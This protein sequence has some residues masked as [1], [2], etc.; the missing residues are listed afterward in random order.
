[1][2]LKID[3]SDWDRE[4]LYDIL[5]KYPYKF[6][7]YGSRVKGCARKYSDLDLCHFDDIPS[8]EALKIKWALEDSNITIKVSLVPV[9]EFSE[10]FFKSIEEDLVE[11]VV[12]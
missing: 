12:N 2:S 11:V 4:A 9:S 5:G 7:A 1:M 3:L 10:S 8:I 6:Y